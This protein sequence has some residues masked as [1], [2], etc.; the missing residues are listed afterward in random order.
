MALRASDLH[1]LS[2]RIHN[3][4]FN[5]HNKSQKTG[6]K[7]LA[8][9]DKGT[10]SENGEVTPATLRIEDNVTRGA[11]LSS[12]LQY[13]LTPEVDMKHEADHRIQRFYQIFN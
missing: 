12:R 10:L 13:D 3:A 2:S 8:D 11:Q 9:E 6:H 4:I 1:P 7:M 5:S